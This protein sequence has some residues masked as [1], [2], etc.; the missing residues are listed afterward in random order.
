MKCSFVLR[1]DNRARNMY[2]GVCFKDLGP[3]GRD[4]RFIKSKTV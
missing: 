4:P 1:T 2:K 3:L